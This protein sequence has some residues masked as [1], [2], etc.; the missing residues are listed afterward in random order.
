VRDDL[1]GTLAIVDAKLAAGFDHYL[2]ESVHAGAQRQRRSSP[3]R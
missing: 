3:D 1:D 2:L